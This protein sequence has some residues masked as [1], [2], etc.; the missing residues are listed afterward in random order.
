[1]KV[2]WVGLGTEQG[3]G[4]GT[5]KLEEIWAGTGQR[6]GSGTGQRR[7]VGHWQSVRLRWVGSGT[8][9]RVGSGT[10][11]LLGWAVGC[12]RYGHRR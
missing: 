3:V 5:G 8:E 2:R 7:W 9:Q 4:S 1:M 11:K 10:G 12:R 6:V